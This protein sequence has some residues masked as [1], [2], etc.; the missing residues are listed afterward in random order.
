M[1][2][3]KIRC[4]MVFVN[5]E[6]CLSAA[7]CHQCAFGLPVLPRLQELATQSPKGRCLRLRAAEFDV[8]D[9]RPGPIVESFY[10][11][12]V[13]TIGTESADVSSAL[14]TVWYHDEQATSHTRRR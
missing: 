11:S 13:R 3:R 12:V 4:E 6:L 8:Q 5:L 10:A 7:T 14:V 2:E 1:K 9:L